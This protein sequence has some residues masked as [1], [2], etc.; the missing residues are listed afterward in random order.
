MGIY[1]ETLARW[2]N[3]R[4]RRGARRLGAPFVFLR[5]VDECGA[6]RG[7]PDAGRRF[8]NVPNTRETRDIH[9]ALPARVGAEVRFTAAQEEPKKKLG[10]AQEQRATIA[11]F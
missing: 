5:A 11:P 4:A 7:D 6:T 10:L 8:R 3:A 9:G 1:W 2:I